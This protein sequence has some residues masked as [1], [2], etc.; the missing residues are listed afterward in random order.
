MAKQKHT[1]D[2]LKSAVSSHTG[3]LLSI[4]DLHVWFEL[5]R[6]GFGRAGFVRA[7]LVTGFTGALC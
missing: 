7:G 4:R 1:I 6:F 2:E 3:P 5:R